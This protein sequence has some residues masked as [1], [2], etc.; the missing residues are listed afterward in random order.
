[1]Q[2]GPR[3]VRGQ[4]SAT[5]ERDGQRTRVAAAAAIAREADQT[6]V[7]VRARVCVCAC[8]RACAHTHVTP[9]FVLAHHVLCALVFTLRNLFAIEGYTAST[10][11]AFDARLPLD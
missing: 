8:V 5:R 1:M 6:P 2:I 3:T 4:A 9:L 7:C 11:T 10:R